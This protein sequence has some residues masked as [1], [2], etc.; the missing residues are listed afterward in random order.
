MPPSWFGMMRKFVSEW[1]RAHFV[2]VGQG[3]QTSVDGTAAAATAEAAAAAARTNRP[4]DVDADRLHRVEIGQLHVESA[5]GRIR[6]DRARVEV[7][8]H[9]LVAGQR[10]VLDPRG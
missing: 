9:D 3:L 8:G 4:E 7:L 5:G 2:V 6:G 1:R 10:L